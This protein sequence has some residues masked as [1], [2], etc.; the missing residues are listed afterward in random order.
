[1]IMYMWIDALC[2]LLQWVLCRDL[3]KFNALVLLIMSNM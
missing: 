2:E 3:D 1:M